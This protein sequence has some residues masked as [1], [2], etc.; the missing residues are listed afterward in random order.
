M[1]ICAGARAR[2][3][4]RALRDALGSP[5]KSKSTVWPSPRAASRQR[6]E[7]RNRAQSPRAA[8]RTPRPTRMR[9][10]VT[11]GKTEHKQNTPHLSRCRRTSP[12]PQVPVRD[13]ARRAHQAQRGLHAVHR[14]RPPRWRLRAEQWHLDLH[15]IDGLVGFLQMKQNK[16]KAPPK[17]RLP[18]KKVP[19]SERRR[20]SRLQGGTAE[21]E[22]LTYDEWSDDE[23]PRQR[24]R[25]SGGR[26]ARKNRL[27]ELSEE[28]RAALD[29]FNMDDFEA[30]ASASF[31]KP[32]HRRDGVITSSCTQVDGARRRAP[33]LRRQPAPG[34]PPGHEARVRRGRPLRL[35]Q[36]RLAGRRHLPQGRAG[37]D[38][39]GR[40]AQSIPSFT[41]STRRS[42]HRSDIG[43]II[44]DARDFEN[45]HAPRPRQRLAPQP[46]A[47]QAPLLPAP[48]RHAGAP[49]A[50][51][52]P[53]P[54]PV[55]E[56]EAAAGE[57][58]R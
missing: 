58:T 29:E 35:G 32:R 6:T 5:P 28:Q 46:P 13:R 12:P 51:A 33:H 31:T 16:K 48:P 53:E 22:R 26:R 56:E 55:A 20:S 9:P 10:R 14:H 30:S 24:S 40:G 3:Q 4:K 8:Y 21:P 18:R 27:V 41:P 38:A 44:E 36:L 43:Q 49:R 34:H 52:E 50:A 37:D 19:E 7:L 45:T 11:G 39:V 57:A 2:T 15:A 17:P 23:R 47:P 1:Y 42:S 54:E 25:G